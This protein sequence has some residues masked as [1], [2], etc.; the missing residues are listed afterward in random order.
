MLISYYNSATSIGG[1]PS[2]IC[3]PST[4][5]DDGKRASPSIGSIMS[6]IISV[7]YGLELT[8]SRDRE[9]EK[10]QVK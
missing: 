2:Q 8:I 10:L 6:S 7:R 9:T 4:F 5:G 1:S 3:S